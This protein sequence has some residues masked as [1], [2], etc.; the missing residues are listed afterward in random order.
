M[1]TAAGWRSRTRCQVTP[2]LPFVA[3]G[4]PTH[5]GPNVS[6][7]DGFR[8]LLAASVVGLRF[9]TRDPATGVA[10]FSYPDGSVARLSTARSP[11]A[12]HS[13]YG[14]PS[15]TLTNNGTSSTTQAATTSPSP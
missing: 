6:F 2:P 12:G 11:S 9:L 5:V 10:V 3:E 14:T 4:R 8:F 13:G 7:D 15:N 1:P